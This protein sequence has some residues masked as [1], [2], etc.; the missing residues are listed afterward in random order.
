MATEKLDTW[1]RR[2]QIAQAALDLA[3]R[4]GLKRV[5]MAAVARRVGL[6]PSALYRHFKGKE[7]VLDAT[8]DLIQNRLLDNVGSVC[9]QTDDAVERLRCL[10]IRHARMIRENRGI[11]QILFSQDLYVEC[12]ARRG[13]VYEGIRRYLA[14]VARIIREGQ[15]MGQIS[16]AL[17]PQ[18]ASVLF[19][20]LIQPSA[21]LWHLSDG[22][23]DVTRQTQRAWPLFLK[24]IQD[25]TQSHKV[26][27]D[28]QQKGTKT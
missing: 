14:E 26:K 28:L 13:R 16:R 17:D 22:D 10:L 9:R 15:E 4:G 7:E 2:E 20:G 25:G 12:P 19:L 24:A 21:I 8:L 18:A 1:I 23:F 27:R 11:P 6:V 3:A 5:S